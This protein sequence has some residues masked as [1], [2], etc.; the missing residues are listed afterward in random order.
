MKCEKS[1][2]ISS[3]FF[4]FFMPTISDDQVQPPQT[5]G[6]ASPSPTMGPATFSGVVAAAEGTALCEQRPPFQKV[7]AYLAP[8]HGGESFKGQKHGF[9]T[10]KTP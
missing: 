10:W 6:D 5:T 3:Y 4:N 8:H 7:R 2:S 9:K 1:E